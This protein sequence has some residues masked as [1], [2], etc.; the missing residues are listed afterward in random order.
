[1]DK[2]LNLETGE[3][4]TNQDIWFG[5]GS[6]KIRNGDVIPLDGSEIKPTEDPLDEDKLGFEID[7]SLTQQERFR[8]F[9]EEYGF[10]PESAD[11]LNYAINSSSYVVS[12]A[13]QYLNTILL[14]QIAI[15]PEDKTLGRRTL[16][17][18]VSDFQMYWRDARATTHL[19]VELGQ[20]AEQN[21]H[22][23]DSELVAS[24][25]GTQRA[26][27]NILRH[28]DIADFV[29]ADSMK[30]KLKTETYSDYLG[31]LQDSLAKLPEEDLTEL[32]NS[33]VDQQRARF[34]FWTDRLK[35]S[36]NHNTV[37]ARVRKEIGLVAV[38]TRE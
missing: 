28:R 6:G 2:K 18:I 33:T 7:G 16:M 14:H 5:D 31:H 1:M 37:R 26:F 23:V 8:V 10:Y 15:K 3:T 11:E 4:E 35:E 38:R 34:K 17:S 36:A 25:P 32:L 13:A 29:E 30:D 9:K 27:I 19:L 22:V 12:S 24:D 21:H 20:S